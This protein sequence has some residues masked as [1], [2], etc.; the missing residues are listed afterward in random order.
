M[1]SFFTAFALAAALAVS[2]QTVAA[3]AEK[4]LTVVEL[5]T[6]QGC[7]S[8]PPA[9][10][11]LGELAKR[12]DLLALSIHVDYWDTSAGRTASPAPITPSASAPT[13][14][15]SACVTSTPRK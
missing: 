1:K 15:S 14:P 4:N 6:S 9:D 5:Y 3:A 11:F 10:A 2:I 7:S 12:D 8:C 13:P